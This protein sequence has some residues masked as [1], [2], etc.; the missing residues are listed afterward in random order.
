MQ[1]LYVERHNAKIS[2]QEQQTLIR[3]YKKAAEEKELL[4]LRLK[5]YI[6]ALDEWI[7]KIKDDKAGEVLIMLEKLKELE[8]HYPKLK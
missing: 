5:T 6:V 4:E 2:E 3:L 1:E 8:S 7:K